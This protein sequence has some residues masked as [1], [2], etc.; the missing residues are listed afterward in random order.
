ME[1]PSRKGGVTGPNTSVNPDEE[2]DNNIEHIFPDPK[3]S[4]RDVKT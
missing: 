4:N 3:N 2:A 1:G